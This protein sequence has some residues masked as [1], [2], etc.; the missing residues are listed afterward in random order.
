VTDKDTEGSPKVPAVRRNRRHSPWPLVIVVALPILSAVLGL[1]I[2]VTLVLLLL[3]TV[4]LALSPHL[5]EHR[6]RDPKK[7]WTQLVASHARLK[8]AYA[9]LNESPSDAD[10]R[11]Q[12]STSLAECLS[13][14][15]SRADS[16]WGPDSGYVEKVRVE[17]ADLSALAALDGGSLAPAPDKGVGRL[18]DLRKQGVLSDREFQAFSERFKA[19]AA[20]KA[21][22]ILETIAGLHLQCR[23]GT[24]TEDDYHA[25]LRGLLDKLD[26][27][28]G[29][30]GLKPA[31][32]A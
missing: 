32:P 10:A 31:A 7:A 28:E 17:I 5:A 4:L 23:G 25:A 15:N 20:E 11:K 1:P 24:M 3:G 30:A 12:F 27:G 6:P 8:S 16:D 21:C 26:R 14:I 29:D 13:I 19:L 2:L 9:A 18:T 22:G